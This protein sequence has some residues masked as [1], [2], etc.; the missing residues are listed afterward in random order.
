MRAVSLFSGVGGMDCGLERAGIT[1]VAQAEADPWRRAVLAARFPGVPCAADVREA[2]ACWG[3]RSLA[4]IVGGEFH[5]ADGG[6]GGAWAQNGDAGG[7]GGDAYGGLGRVDLVV[8]GP[9]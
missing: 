7:G 9:P 4:G 6:R 3:G 2:P 1:V 5:G 8:G